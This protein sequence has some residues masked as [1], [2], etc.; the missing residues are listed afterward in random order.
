MTR[1]ISFESMMIVLVSSS[2]LLLVLVS[3]MLLVLALPFAVTS[4]A[5]RTTVPESR[6]NTTPAAITS[7]VP[8]FPECENLTGLLREISIFRSTSAV[9]LWDERVDGFLPGASVLRA[10]QN[11][12]LASVLHEKSISDEHGTAIE[13]CKRVYENITCKY[14]QANIEEGRSIYGYA[15]RVTKECS[16]EVVTARSEGLAAWTTA[17]KEDDCPA[18]AQF[19]RT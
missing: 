9:L 19:G 8:S 18:R 13:S 6:A 14:S 17:R 15:N 3:F 10:Q 4:C 11:A 7:A 2:R 12:V 5:T 1:T 16:M